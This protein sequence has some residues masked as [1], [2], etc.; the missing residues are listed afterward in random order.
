M[1]VS[2]EDLLALLEVCTEQGYTT[3]MFIREVREVIGWQHGMTAA[4]ALARYTIDLREITV[5]ETLQGR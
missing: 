5:Y 3:P 1:Q 2:D 4:I